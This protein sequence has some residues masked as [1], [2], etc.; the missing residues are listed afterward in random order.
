MTSQ[1]A[2]GVFVE[3]LDTGQSAFWESREWWLGT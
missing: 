1:N 2:S 3:A